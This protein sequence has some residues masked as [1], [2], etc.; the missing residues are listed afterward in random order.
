MEVIVQIIRTKVGF[1]RRIGVIGG[2]VKTTVIIHSKRRYNEA[3]LDVP[4]WQHSDEHQ[5][6]H[7][8]RGEHGYHRR[9]PIAL[10]LIRAHVHDAYIE[11]HDYAGDRG[12][13]VLTNTHHVECGAEPYPNRRD[14]W[15]NLCFEEAHDMWS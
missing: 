13:Y 5:L 12:E 6:L 7:C 14:N 2:F 11:S 3:K 4:R 1:I 15:L 9:I 8:M 10:R